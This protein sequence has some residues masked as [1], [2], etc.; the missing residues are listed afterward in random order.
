MEDTVIIEALKEKVKPCHK[1]PLKPIDDIKI[2]IDKISCD[3]QSIKH[4]IR[5]IMDAVNH[6][7]AQASKGWWY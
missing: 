2:Q 3:V 5:I 4:D 7:E 1:S 6:Q